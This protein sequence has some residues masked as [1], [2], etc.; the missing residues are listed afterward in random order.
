MWPTNE[1]G[2][3][4]RMDIDILQPVHCGGTDV[5]VKNSLTKATHAGLVMSLSQISGSANV[6][7]FYF[8]DMF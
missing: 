8:G 6:V 1:G 4:Y 2:K 5:T 3:I 7:E